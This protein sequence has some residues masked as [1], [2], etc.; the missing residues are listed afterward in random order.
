MHP[1]FKTMQPKNLKIWPH[2][3]HVPTCDMPVTFCDIFPIISIGNHLNSIINIFC[4][5]CDIIKLFVS[6]MEKFHLWQNICYFVSNTLPHLLMKVLYALFFTLWL[7]PVFAQ[8]GV[9]ELR[10]KVANATSL[11][12]KLT[13]YKDIVYAY[14]AVN[15]DSAFYYAQQGLEYFTQNKYR[16]GQAW[17]L[18]D[19]AEIDDDHG[20]EEPAKQRS[21]YALEIFKDEKNARGIAEVSNDLGSIMGKGGDFESAISYFKTALKNF[22]LCNSPVGVMRVY[23]NLGITYER[24]NDTTKAIFYLK[25]ADSISRRSPLSD[26]VINLYN[27]IGAYYAD[28]GDTGKA[29]KYFEEGLIKSD[30]PEYV[31]T[32]LS[33]LINTG[34]MYC[35]VGDNKKGVAYLEEALSMARS[36]NLP[37]EEANILTNLAIALQEK[38]KG[39]ALSYLKDALGISQKIGDK[40]LQADIYEEMVEVYKSEKDYKNAFETREKRQMILDSIISINKTREIAGISAIHELEKSNLKVRQLEVMNERNLY[41]RNIMMTIAVFVIIFLIVLAIFYERTVLLNKKL[42]IHEQELKHLNEMKDKLFSVIGHDL[43]TPI[44]RIP[45]MLD[46]IEE[47]ETTEEE[48]KMLLDSMREHSKVSVET[49]DKLLFWGKSLVRGISMNTVKFQPKKYIRGAIEL[50]R[51]AAQEKNIA[52]TDHTPAELYVYAD[53]THFDFIIRNLVVNAIKY[54]HMNGQIDI[55]ADSDSRA[56]YTIF[57]VKDNGTGMTMKQMG[58]LFEPAVSIPG[59]ANEQGSGIGLMLCK[60]FVRQNDGDIWVESEPGK[61]TTF[62]FSVK[63][64]T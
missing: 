6:K 44:A 58:K 34:M 35:R 54:T 2:N 46:L 23:S 36:K 12:Q 10:E 7:S 17:M 18:S 37:E 31:A 27:D 40:P 13:A 59:T 3:T 64:A 29:L 28:R 48:T 16:G 52:I 8:S 4:R 33:C 53:V 50:K 15:E 62:F 22:E 49:L 30:K 60:E 1:H 19:L 61:G 26:A 43:K 14:Q 39:K 20:R 47:G 45:V 55:S 11:S 42:V 5:F 51:L 56:G 57:A 25:L 41:E 63:S 9:P 21:L 38:D 24:Y 32:H